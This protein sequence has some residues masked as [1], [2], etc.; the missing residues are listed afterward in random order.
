MK[1]FVPILIVVIFAACNKQDLNLPS[2]IRKEYKLVWSDEFDGTEIDQTKWNYR[3]TGATRGY[4]VVAE[5]NCFLNGEGQLVIETRQ[6]GEDYFVG[7][8]GTQNTYLATYGYFECRAKMND[9]LGPHVAFWLQSPTYG[10][11]IGNPA[12]SGTEIDIF[13]YHVNKGVNVVYHN[14]HWDGYAADHQHA[15]TEV[16]IDGVEE[17]Y[18]TFGLEW[19]PEEYIFY[20][21]GEETWR[22]TEAVSQRSEYMILSAEL[23]GWGGDFSHSNFPDPVVFDWVR[24]YQKK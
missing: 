7:Q 23:T 14:L 19:T 18:H 6:D 8:V 13:E 20:V 9:E 12:E 17:G 15:G 10:Q 21:D 16:Y 3:A 4:A 1:S 2:H 11:Q 24:V 5:D 22:S